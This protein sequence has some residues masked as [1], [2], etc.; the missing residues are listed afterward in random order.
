MVELKH[1]IKANFGETLESDFEIC[2]SFKERITKEEK[3]IQK[4]NAYTSNFSAIYFL[5][6]FY[7][8]KALKILSEVNFFQLS[9]KSKET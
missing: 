3:I 4:D 2:N 9:S 1:W 5:S 8:E 6:K 7:R